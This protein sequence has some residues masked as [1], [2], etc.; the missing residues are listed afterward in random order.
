MQKT[1]SIMYDTDHVKDVV[2]E[3]TFNTVPERPDVVTVIGEL[4]KKLRSTGSPD[5]CMRMGDASLNDIVLRRDKEITRRGEKVNT[6]EE[7]DSTSI[8]GNGDLLYAGFILKIKDPFLPIRSAG[9]A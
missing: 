3:V 2:K 4:R 5:Y 6:L 7:L 1:V 9:N 8:I